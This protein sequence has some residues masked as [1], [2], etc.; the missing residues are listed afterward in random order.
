[1]ETGRNNKVVL[2]RYTKLVQA[3]GPGFHPDTPGDDYTNLPDGYLPRDVNRI[4]RE[5]VQADI[6]V[7]AVA[8]E[9]LGT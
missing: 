8:R 6:D 2:G 3:I 5:A 1:M 4:L 9:V 7:Y